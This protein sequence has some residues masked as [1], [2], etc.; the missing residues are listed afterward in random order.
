MCV[1][2]LSAYTEKSLKVLC[3]SLSSDENPK[4]KKNPGESK[5]AAFLRFLRKDCSIDFDEP[6][7][8][9]QIRE[10]CRK[11]RNSFAHGDWDTLKDLVKEINLREAFRAVS[12]LLYA[13]EDAAWESPWGVVS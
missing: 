2:M 10:E 7:T 5:I 4:P 12:D 13:I 1:V 11:V 8:S 9:F 6:A 3:S